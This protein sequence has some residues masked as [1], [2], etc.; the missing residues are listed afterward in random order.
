MSPSKS[1]EKEEEA[2][3]AAA[4]AGLGQSGAFW[5]NIV[6]DHGRD[7]KGTFLTTCAAHMASVRLR[8]MWRAYM[9]CE[10]REQCCL[11]VY[12]AAVSVGKH[13]ALH[14]SAHTGEVLLELWS[15]AKHNALNVKKIIE[16]YYFFNSSA[17]GIRC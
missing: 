14:S 16:F 7:K 17:C 4:T 8:G 1:T 10:C 9:E 13:A 12:V 3:A 15:A 5:R 2:A 11:S 6:A